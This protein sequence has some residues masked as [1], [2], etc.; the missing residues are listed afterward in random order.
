MWTGTRLQCV[1]LSLCDKLLSV[2][3]FLSICGLGHKHFFPPYLPRFLSIT[4]QALSTN[5]RI[6]VSC[7]QALSV[8]T[9]KQPVLCLWPPVPV[10]PVKILEGLPAHTYS[11]SFLHTLQLHCRPLH[12]SPSA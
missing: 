4:D 9:V 5:L 1:G 10:V 11:S 8:P 12:F 6:P 3:A 7:C 2:K